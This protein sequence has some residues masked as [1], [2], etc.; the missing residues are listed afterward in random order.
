M[1]RPWDA[2]PPR[3]ALAAMA[4]E[5][6]RRGWMAGTAGNLSA[7]SGDGRFWITA[8]GR[9]KGCLDPVRDFLEVDLEGRPL[10]APSGARP[11]AETAIHAALYRRFP[12]A[13]AC[14]HVH[15]LAAARVSHALPPHL[16]ELP[17]PALEILKGLGVWE[18]SPR[19]ALPLFANHL[20][21]ARIA[22]AVARRFAVEPPAVPALLIRSHGVTVWGESLQR[23]YD[24]L[25]CVEFLLA[26][27]DGAPSAAS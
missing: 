26:Y 22:R 12:E 24:H 21:V 19:V 3:E 17:L 7:R 25:E 27:L 15:S 11:S 23:A 8:S 20:E 1:S 18:A 16:A 13:R 9:P 4:A 2:L 14:L 5:F 10:E 6:H